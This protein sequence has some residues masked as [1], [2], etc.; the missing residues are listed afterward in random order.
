MSRPRNYQTEALI[1]R[2]TRLGEADRILSLYTPKLGKIQAVA[3]GVRR[4]RSKMSGHLELVTHSLVSLARGRNIDTVTNTRTI[5]AFLPLKSDLLR[6]AAALY[7]AELV[8]RFTADHIENEPL[9][10]LLLATWHKLAGTDDIETALRFFELHLLETLGYRPELEHCVACKGTLTAAGNWF[11]P[12]A[13]GVICLAC[14]PRYPQRFP[15]SPE[16]LDTLRTLQKSE[17]ATLPTGIS[18]A[19]L[20]ELV[21]L[22]GRYL[23]HLLE[24]EVKSARWLDTL[25]MQLNRN[26]ASHTA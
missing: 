11:G 8:D 21:A 5:T 19:V 14:A 13:G 9:F 26:A 7:T 4:P 15:V 1:I 23:E 18:P 6:G 3:K 12:A 2:K 24:K 25:R 22:L 17:P 20:S 10:K 16:A